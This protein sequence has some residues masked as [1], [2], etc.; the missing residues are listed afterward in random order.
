MHLGWQWVFGLSVCSISATSKKTAVSVEVSHNGAK[1]V[2]VTIKEGS[3]KNTQILDLNGL[4]NFSGVT[5]QFS[6][7][8]S[9]Q[10]LITVSESGAVS[11]SSE[12]DY[13]QLCHDN[14]VPCLFQSK[15]K[16][17]SQLNLEVDSNREIV[18]FHI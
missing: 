3:L 12:I 8:A 18:Y 5:R 14:R 6:L 17:R 16:Y 13:E 2:S 9:S 10:E 4:F 7:Q 11:L 15:V 1:R